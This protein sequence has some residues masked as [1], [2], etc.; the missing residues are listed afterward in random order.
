MMDIFKSSFCGE[1]HEFDLDDEKT[2]QAQHESIKDYCEKKYGGTTHE[3]WDKCVG[4]IGY[5]HMYMN[6][7]HPGDHWEGQKEAIDVLCKEFA[8][9]EREHRFKDTPETRLWFKKFMFRFTDEIE[10]MC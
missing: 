7:F 1:T 3:L 2:Y 4:E 6:Y 5:A 8:A 9:G 10:N